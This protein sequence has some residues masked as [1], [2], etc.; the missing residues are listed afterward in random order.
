[1]AG[2]GLLSADYFLP[3]V[4]SR[5]K[6][7]YVEGAN[8]PLR[9][10]T[11]EKDAMSFFYQP[12]AAVNTEKNLITLQGWKSN[13]SIF[14]FEATLKKE[15]ELFQKR[16]GIA[17]EEALEKYRVMAA[18]FIYL[19]LSRQ[20]KVYKVVGR[21]HI[22]IVNENGL[23]CRYLAEVDELNAVSDYIRQNHRYKTTQ[24]HRVIDD[25]R[26]FGILAKEGKKQVLICK[27]NSNRYRAINT[28]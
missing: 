18:G 17:L 15:L 26:I 19:R 8:K 25:E 1:M 7:V 20:E 12:L 21:L 4:Q 28:R 23:Y 5:L 6:K 11:L 24:F 14:L 22:F 13:F 2:K 27:P 3:A 9:E 16:Y 10:L